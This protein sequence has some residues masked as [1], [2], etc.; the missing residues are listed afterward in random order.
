MT[1]QRRSEAQKRLEDFKTEWTNILWGMYVQ[2]PELFD[3]EDVEALIYLRNS[4]LNDQPSHTP[5]TFGVN[6]GASMQ[7]HDKT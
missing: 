3:A 6:D 7:V 1:M 5:D 2:F 4:E